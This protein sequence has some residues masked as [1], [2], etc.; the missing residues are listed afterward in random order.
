[1]LHRERGPWLRCVLVMCAEEWLLLVMCAAGDVC[2]AASR[3]GGGQRVLT[4]ARAGL[5]A[6]SSMTRPVRLPESPG[7]V[8]CSCGGARVS[9]GSLDLERRRGTGRLV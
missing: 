9:R 1:M 5:R 2:G 8:R 4:S 6:S 7:W 3:S